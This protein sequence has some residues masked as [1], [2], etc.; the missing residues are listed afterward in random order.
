MDLSEGDQ[1]LAHAFRRVIQTV[2]IIPSPAGASPEIEIRGHLA[3]LIAATFAEGSRSGF[4][5]W[6]RKRDS[7]PRPRH[8]E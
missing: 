3:T 1:G 8:Y 2:T 4:V 6:C 5:R 7:N